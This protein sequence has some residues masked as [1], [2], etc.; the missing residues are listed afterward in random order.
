MT[1]LNTAINSYDELDYD[2]SSI[3]ADF[4]ALSLEING[5]PLAFLDSGASAQKP[6]RVLEKMDQVYRSEYANVHRGAY[7][8]SQIATDNYE[9][10]RVTVANFLNAKTPDEIVFTRNVTSAINLVAHSYGRTFLSAGDEIIIS[11]MEH[12]ANIVPW[13]LLRE[14]VGIEIKVVPIDD[15]G[16][17]LMEDYEKLLGPKTKLVAVTQVSNVL[18]TILPVKEIVRKAHDVGAHVLIDGCQGVVH[19]GMDVQALDADF[20]A[21]TGH[22]LYGPSGIGVLW[23][24]LDLLNRMPPYEGGGDMIESVTFEKTTY[25]DAPARFEAGTPPIVEAIGLAAAIDYVTSIGL[26]K[27]TTHE[28]KLLNYA[29][30]ELSQINGLRII[31]QAN[32]KA[33]IISFVLDDVHPHDIS[34]I[35]D[36]KGVA[37]RAG[38][39]CAQPLMDRYEVAATAR[40]SLGMYNNTEDID[41]LVG[42][43]NYVREIFS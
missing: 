27:I 34:T 22:K 17:F 33:A 20:Y 30:N 18:G 21:F 43:L 4:P 14:A 40:A 35:I 42:A 19:E 29:T 32:R 36:S 11:H 7:S 10:A 1:A 24:K 26:D 38:H 5:H 39:H 8:L 3:R 9:S 28:S 23:G 37:V 25:R 31:G 15:D 2:I 6:A 13:Q 16:N 41:Q 12:H